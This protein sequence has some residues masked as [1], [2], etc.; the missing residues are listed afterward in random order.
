MAVLPACGAGRPSQSIFLTSEKSQGSLSF[1]PPPPFPVFQASQPATLVSCLLSPFSS[2]PG[3][4]LACP[5]GG[6]KGAG[7]ET[8]VGPFF[9]P[10]HSASCVFEDVAPTV[11]CSGPGPVGG[12]LPAERPGPLG[13]RG[14]PLRPSESGERGAPGPGAS[15]AE[16]LGWLCSSQ[17]AAPPLG[18]ITH[19]PRAQH[20]S[21]VLPDFKS[22]L[23]G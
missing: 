5:G 9:H 21:Y 2:P 11:G 16:S 17:V 7:D 12:L 23:M 19:V 1:P 15:C 20:F 22:D 18:I 10:G 8:P 14:P 13:W 3:T 4:L 6:Q